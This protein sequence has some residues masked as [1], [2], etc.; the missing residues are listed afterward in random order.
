MTNNKEVANE[1]TIPSV[2]V[3]STVENNTTGKSQEPLKA[4][5]EAIKEKQFQNALAALKDLIRARNRSGSRTVPGAFGGA[6][7]GI[8][9]KKKFARYIARNTIE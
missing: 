1:S 7:P 8:K 3:S 6:H 4:D 9:R 5:A 2:D